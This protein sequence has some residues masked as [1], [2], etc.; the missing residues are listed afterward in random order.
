MQVLN[1]KTNESKSRI[2]DINNTH[3]IWEIRLIDLP[4]LVRRRINKIIF[5]NIKNMYNDNNIINCTIFL[6]RR[7]QKVGFI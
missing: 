7:I 6:Y 5:W 3:K 1:S 2:R 4:P